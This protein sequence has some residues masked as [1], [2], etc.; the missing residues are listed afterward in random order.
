MAQ[1]QHRWLIGAAVVAAVLFCVVAAF[2]VVGASRGA[3]NAVIG[4]F[5][6]IE[7]PGLTGVFKAI[8]YSGEFY[9]YLVLCVVLLIIPRTRVPFGAPVTAVLVVD[10][11]ANT[12]LKYIFREPRPN[13]HRL[14]SE[15]GFSFPSGHAMFA[16]AIAATLILLVL[17]VVG[18]RVWT[19]VLS[20]LLIV[21]AVAVGASRVYLGVHWPVDILGGYLAGFVTFVLVIVL[22][23]YWAISLGQVISRR[24]GL[25]QHASSG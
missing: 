16:S 22:W 11:A 2:S 18:R 17:R 5:R 8:T 7:S 21:F 4:F 23:D 1:R 24:F 6:G 3:D 12:V 14:I 25:A 19:V 13:T 20:C 9:T 10:G 15:T